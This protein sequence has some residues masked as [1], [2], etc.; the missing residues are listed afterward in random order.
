LIKYKAL[1]LSGFFALLC[2]G[3]CLLGLPVLLYPSHSNFGLEGKTVEHFNGTFTHAQFSK[4]VNGTLMTKNSE[5]GRYRAFKVG[6]MS[7]LINQSG[8]VSGHEIELTH[9]GNDV[10]TCQIDGVRLC[11]ARCSDATDCIAMQRW[12]SDRTIQFYLMMLFVLAVLFAVGSWM[13][14]RNRRPS[15][16][17]SPP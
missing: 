8:L 11:A 12:Q 6:V 17:A 7:Y 14:H 13:Q 16:V 5:T 15:D 1:N 2:L 4:G 9:L 10:L 3:L